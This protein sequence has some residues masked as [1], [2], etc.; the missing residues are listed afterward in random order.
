MKT[1]GRLYDVDSRSQPE[2]IRVAKDDLGV[3]IC[4]FELFEANAFDG[5][6]RADGHEYRRL[7]HAPPRHQTPRARLSLLSLNCKSNRRC[8]CLCILCLFVAD[9]CFSII[10][11]GVAKKSN[12]SRRRFNKYRSY[13]KCSP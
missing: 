2:M 9:L 10:R 6:G 3:E 11:S 4:G 1:A 8:H 5:S 7:D 13:E 12:S